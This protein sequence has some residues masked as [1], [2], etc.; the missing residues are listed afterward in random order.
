MGRILDNFGTPVGKISREFLRRRLLVRIGC[1]VDDVLC[2]RQ[3]VKR[4]FHVEA[5]IGLKREP[6]PRSTIQPSSSSFRR[7]CAT[8]VLPCRHRRREPPHG[9]CREQSRRYGLLARLLKQS[10][11]LLG[12]HGSNL[13]LEIERSWL[14]LTPHQCHQKPRNPPLGLGTYPQSASSNLVSR[15]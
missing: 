2:L 15:D 9:T 10:F 13:E 4:A 5:P 12:S 6:S 8:V 1:G 3:I 11:C 7:A 14:P